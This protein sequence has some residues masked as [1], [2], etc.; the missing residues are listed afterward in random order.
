MLC[1]RPPRASGWRSRTRSEQNTLAGLRCSSKIGSARSCVADSLS[2]AIDPPPGQSFVSTLF[3]KLVTLLAGAATAAFLAAGWAQRDA[4]YAAVGIVA[5][6]LLLVLYG[7]WIY[8]HAATAIDR[9]ERAAEQNA[10]LLELVRQG[11]DAGK[12]QTRSIQTLTAGQAELLGL[13]SAGA[14]AQQ[15]LAEKLAAVEETTRNASRQA[16]DS[17]ELALRAFRDVSAMQADLGVATADRL[18]LVLQS[19]Q[20]LGDL[21]RQLLGGTKSGQSALDAQLVHVR[22]A[23]EARL[24]S[25]EAVLLPF[26]AT[27][28]KLSR[29]ILREVMSEKAVLSPLVTAS[30]EG[31][32]SIR[33]DISSVRKK[34]SEK[35]DSQRAAL[36]SFMHSDKNLRELAYRA[37]GKMQYETVQEIEALAQLR[38]LFDVQQPTPLLG[39]FAMQPVSMLA[40]VEEVL[41]RKP[42]LIVECGS[43]TSTLWIARA[44]AR[45]GKGRLVS[46]EHLKEY[47][48]KTSRSLQ[49]QGLEQWVDLRLAPLQEMHVNGQP[50][51]WY[52]PAA[53][54]DLADIDILSVDGPPG[55]IG[56]LA[57]YPALPMLRG[58]LAA[59]AL[60]LVD[61]AEREDERAVMERWKEEVNGIWK[62]WK[63]AGRTHALAYRDFA[64]K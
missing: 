58:K 17:Q 48:D 10:A 19:L 29:Q 62:A 4:T 30:A 15:Q 55:F 31:A 2:E 64:D 49:Q 28:E 59:D 39:G 27:S 46:L 22:E 25:V 32:A 43:G 12:Q 1:G 33:S 41:A 56:P 16:G 54:A 18:Q 51:Q 40:L 20:E 5:F 53:I 45:N 63:I 6:L 50:F 34:I 3:L 38:R 44:L 52:D 42:G 7:V 8:R 60:I 23:V 37:L 47:F 26:V 57:R 11:V 24:I 9:L 35:I 21:S 13:Q 14:T 61:D 36:T